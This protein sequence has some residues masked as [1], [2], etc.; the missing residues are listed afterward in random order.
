MSNSVWLSYDYEGDP[1]TILE[2]FQNEPYPFF[3]DSS[4]RDPH[5]GRFSFIGF[6]PFEVF[7]ARGKDSL[8][9]L[10]ERFDDYQSPWEESSPIFP[11]GFV[12]YVSYDLGLALESIHPK[13]GEDLSLSHIAGGFYDF[14]ISI[15]HRERQLHISSTGLPEKFSYLRKE[16]AQERIEKILKRLSS[17]LT[18]RQT[19]PEFDAISEEGSPLNFKCNF[20]REDYLKAVATAKDY[21]G[22]GEI[23]QVNLSQRFSL[24]KSCFPR[25]PSAFEIYKILRRLSPSGFGAYWDCGAYQILSSS[26]ERFLNV[27]GRKV[28]TRPMKG[29]RGRGLTPQEDWNNKKDL[30]DS[31]KDRAELLMITDLLR[32]DLGKVC[33][34]GSVQVHQLRTLEAYKTV[35]QATSTVGGIL[36]KDKDLFHLLEACFPG[37]SVT[38]CPKIRAMRIIDELEPTRRSIYTGALGY[39]SFSG[40]M[41]WNILIRTLLLSNE[42]IHFQV[43]SGIVADSIPER[44][45]E[46]T[47]IKAKA[48][49][50]CLSLTL[51]GK[52][53]EE[54]S[55][56]AQGISS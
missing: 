45:Y 4:W 14:I 47:L 11:A 5:L 31:P 10:R 39:V 48:L 50:Q 36:K 30:M 19:Q 32:N 8:S 35:Y 52:T 27:Q 6:D 33:E 49:R 28:E 53:R 55:K 1:I 56:L 23:Y 54:S 40:N 25:R 22:Q 12:G 44:E 3:L 17:C 34:Y 38:G 37:G 51:Q 41:D 18:L 43:G 20:T 21:I 15:D 26:P 9:Q 24:D 42:A 13:S 29:T 46:E 7:Q 16:R 2:A